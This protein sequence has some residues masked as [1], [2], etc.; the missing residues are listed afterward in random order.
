MSTSTG[1][2]AVTG[3]R[4]EPGWDVLRSG[5]VL[6]VVLYHA[7]FLGPAL[8]PDLIPRRISFDHQVGASLLLVISAYFACAT[9]GRHSPGRY[10]WGR[11]ARLLPPFL[12][13]VPISWL[14]LRYLSPVEWGDPPAAQLWQNW[15]ML[16]HWDDGRFPWLD[17][18]FW[19]LP[20]QLM[21]FTAAAVLSV[22]T[23]GSGHRLRVLLWTVLL[24][25]LAQ[26]PLRLGVTSAGEPPTWYGIAVDGVGFHRLHLFVAGITVWLWS[27]GRIRGPHATALLGVCAL[28][29]F[30][31]TTTLGPEGLV[32]DVVASALVCTGVAL[33]AMVAW[34]PRPGSRTPQ[35]VARGFRWL[36]GISYGVYL[37][38]QTMGYV[39]MRRLQDLGIGPLLQ[40]AAMLV[41]AVL[42]GW[43]LTRLVE[44]PVHT[45]LMRAWDRWVPRARAA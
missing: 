37:V 7:T 27:T 5:F 33:I 21:A 24:V 10:W 22:T 30:A 29:Q 40:S 39:L 3:S 45:A 17:P 43:L 28:A 31:H 26:W 18:A 1:S 44:R 9:L 2:P 32:E 19:T 36:A 34:L 6:L 13:A 15:L 12:V 14:A 35:P 4:R 16:G 41:I 42:L 8:H 11:I 23:W 38:H 25:P 20:L